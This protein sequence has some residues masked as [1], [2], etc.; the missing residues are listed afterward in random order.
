MAENE[1]SIPALDRMSSLDFSNKQM[2]MAEFHS[3][4]LYQLN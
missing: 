1:S 3:N 4:E 2:S